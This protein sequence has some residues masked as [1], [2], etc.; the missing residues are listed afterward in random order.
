LSPWFGIG[1]AV[2]AQFLDSGGVEGK[3]STGSCRK[4]WFAKQLFWG[5]LICLS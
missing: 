2:V 5:G 4:L 1:S 3:L